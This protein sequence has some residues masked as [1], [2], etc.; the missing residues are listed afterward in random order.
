[1]MIIMTSALAGLSRTLAADLP[2]ATPGRRS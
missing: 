1:V 2:L